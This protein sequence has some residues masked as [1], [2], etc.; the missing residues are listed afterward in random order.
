VINIYRIHYAKGYYA[1]NN[2]SLFI[3]RDFVVDQNQAVVDANCWI[4]LSK[5]ELAESIGLI[6]LKTI[7]N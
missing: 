2:G 6:Q 7:G 1:Y 4:V 3:S 5:A